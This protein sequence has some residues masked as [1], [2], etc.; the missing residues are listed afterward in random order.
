[1]IHIVKVIVYE[2]VPYLMR[3]YRIHPENI[4]VLTGTYTICC[5]PEREGRCS[6]IFS[7]QMLKKCD[8]FVLKKIFC[9]IVVDGIIC[10]VTVQA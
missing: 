7:A 6:M 3:I 1:M 4:R 8:G 10:L 5:N 2:D 9:K